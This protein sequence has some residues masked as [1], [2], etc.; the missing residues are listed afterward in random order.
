VSSSGR[1]CFWE[2]LSCCSE[3]H[4]VRHEIAKGRGQATENVFHDEGKGAMS[5]VFYCQSCGARFKVDPRLAGKQG[6]C[7]QCGQHMTVPT[8]VQAASKAAKPELAAVGAGLRPGS[9]W[10]GQVQASEVS[11]APLTIDRMPAVKKP[12]MFPED[13]LADSSPYLLAEPVKRARGEPVSQVSETKVWW[14]RQLGVIER[15]FRW[16]NQS[17]YL[18]SVPFLMVLILGVMIRS[19]PMALFGAA[20]VVVLNIARLISGVFNV[21]VIPFRDG[22]NWK[23]LKKPIRR[24]I[25]PAITIG[26]VGLAFAFIPWLSK[27]GTSK[28]MLHGH[29]RAGLEKLQTK[30]EDEQ[31]K[32]KALEATS[33][34][35]P[36]Q[37]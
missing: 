7:K 29:F 20:V 5:T 22:I 34:N 1:C 36:L 19:H 15:F 21:A 32:A 31:E 6:R 8:G 18:V 16:I 3:P 33:K 24:L 10:L 14:R 26:L 11:L 17:A 12:S 35:I 27:G 2:W 4:V 9:N 30:I 25:E 23:R 28:E 37:P 13:D